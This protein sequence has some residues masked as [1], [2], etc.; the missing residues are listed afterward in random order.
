MPF[1]EKI[2]IGNNVISNTDYNFNYKLGKF[3]F[4]D[5]LEY[6]IFDTIFISYEKI[7]LDLKKE[8]KNRSLVYK[9]D[10]RTSDTIKVVKSISQ[11]LTTESIF[12]E[13]IQKS[14]TILRGFTVGTNKDFTLNSGLRLQLS[15]RLSDG[16]TLEAF[17]QYKP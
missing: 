15:G 16:P 5:S 17:P 11:P 4:S 9:F 14:G 3:S 2:K 8:Y 7:F 12:G 1:S 13:G 6:S 10:E